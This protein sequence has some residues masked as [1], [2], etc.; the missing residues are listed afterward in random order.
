MQVK[1][2]TAKQIDTRKLECAQNGTCFICDKALGKKG[3]RED[4]GRLFCPH[5]PHPRPTA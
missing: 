2:L 5:H 4:E 3:H 1:L